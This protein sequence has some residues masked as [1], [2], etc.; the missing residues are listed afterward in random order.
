MK[1]SLFTFIFLLMVTATY[2]QKWTLMYQNDAQGN[3]V[4][5]SLDNLRAAVRDGLP[6]RVAWKHQSVS[7]PKIKVEHIADA[8]FLTIMSDEVVFAQIDPIV[9]QTPNF[10]DQFIELKEN[11]SWVLMAASNGKSDMMM[12]NVMTGEIVSHNERPL[13]IDWYVLNQ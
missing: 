8:K 5:G 12:R 7:N 13:A 1:R 4:S 6:I 2:G 9:G 3:T 11:L 10:D